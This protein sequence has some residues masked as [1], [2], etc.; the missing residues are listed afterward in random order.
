MTGYLISFSIY[1]MAMVGLIFIAL[2]VFKAFSSHGFGK[3]SSLIKIEDAM[4]LSAR[5]TLYV[6]KTEN[7]R[8]LIASDIDR[9]AL[10]ARLDEEKK[11]EL[12]AR[13]D[14]SCYLTSFDGV[15]SLE[16]FASVIDFKKERAKKGPVMK[17]LA[18]KLSEI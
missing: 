12:Q 2:F 17:E 13:E 9:T 14:K 18:K 3:K 5:K 4:K 6:V 8:F 16:E 7:Q 1:T 10:I 11:E 15:D